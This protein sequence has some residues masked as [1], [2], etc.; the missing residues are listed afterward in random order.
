MCFD[1]FK[2]IK[3][4]ILL[5]ID[6]T[7]YFRYK[8][9]YYYIMRGFMKLLTYI[10]LN[11]KILKSFL[12]FTLFISFSFANNFF[13]FAEDSDELFDFG[14]IPEIN[15]D[16]INETA[17]ISPV[18]QGSDIPF[19][20]AQYKIEDSATKA[21]EKSE[22]II[23]TK[24]D[25]VNTINKTI[26][27]D[28]NGIPFEMS[29]FDTMRDVLNFSPSLKALEENRQSIALEIWNARSGYFPSL[30]TSASY[31]YGRTED[32]TI[33]DPRFAPTGSASITLSQSIWNGFG[34]W[35]TVASNKYKLE[36]I[37]NRVFDNQTTLALEGLIAHL[38]V[39]R[40]KEALELTKV[41]IETHRTIIKQL[42][43][44]RASG[45]NTVA[46]V[47][48]AQGRLIRTLAEE[49]NAINA[50]K[51][52]VTNYQLLT[53]H[54]PPQVLL[55]GELPSQ[56][57][58]NLEEMRKAALAGNPKILAYNADYKAANKQVHVAM[59]NFFPKF[60]GTVSAEYSNDVMDYEPSQAEK[61][62]NA[63]L[64]V[65]WNLFNGFGTVNST[66]IAKTGERMAQ[67]DLINTIN[68]I[69]ADVEN[70]YN[71][72]NNSTALHEMYSQA[73]VYNFATRDAYMRQF[74]FGSRPLIDLL[75]AESELYSTQ[76]QLA[77][78]NA[79]IILNNWRL[80]AL[81]GKLIDELEGIEAIIKKEGKTKSSTPL[82]FDP[83]KDAEI[84]DD[85]TVMID[86]EIS[87]EESEDGSME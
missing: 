20:D 87:D 32:P 65:S 53:G 29:V 64:G 57:L 18:E 85:D 74:R 83:P 25:D 24:E 80:L 34:T 70:T 62:I 5:L 44:L 73:L 17:I 84:L 72:L 78:T 36:S 50:Y 19:E 52:A 71:N 15:S 14:S 4:I 77:I 8:K 11:T 63:T 45:I 2:T 55:A 79:N 28:K 1:F 27:L 46:D 23:L 75:D 39:I 26:A 76:I 40:T 33:S 82:S 54:M 12:A 42:E 22:E 86:G 7:I 51:L 68:S 9:G 66:R 38:E 21:V 3:Q 69:S 30:D 35:N 67:Q 56:S 10:N 37:D 59:S 16:D 31:G 58:G 6:T 81:Q 49:E 48:Q 60:T 41:Y 43:L 61:S 13:A 47:T